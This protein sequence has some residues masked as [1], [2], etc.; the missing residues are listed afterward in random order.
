MPKPIDDDAVLVV[1]AAGRE[2]GKRLRK[3]LLNRGVPHECA[4]CGQPPVWK[5]FELTLHVD[6]I[7][8]NALDCRPENLRFLCPNCHS[9]TP[10]FGTRVRPVKE[11]FGFLTPE[12]VLAIREA[13][14]PY[15]KNRRGNVPAKVL[16]ERYGVSESMI[17]HIVSGREWRR[18]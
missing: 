12:R 2:D 4:L 11:V 3:A 13:W 7:D 6:H 9:Q 18:I 16:A 15:V 10:T 14:G 5:G 17:S 1:R 8:G